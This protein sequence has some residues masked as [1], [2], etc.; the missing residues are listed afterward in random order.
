MRAWKA[1]RN[2][3]SAEGAT[4]SNKWLSHLRRSVLIVVHALTGVAINYR[5]FGPNRQIHQ[6]LI[7][8]PN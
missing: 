7:F 3:K 4:V 2:E 5:P 1:A 8:I 6:K